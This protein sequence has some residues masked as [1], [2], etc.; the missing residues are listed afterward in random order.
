[1]KCY[2]HHDADAVGVCSQCGQGVCDACA[3][4]I[5]GKLYCKEDADRV[6]SPQRE[7]EAA[8]IE[9]PMR[10]QVASIFFILYGV[11]G[12]GVG[13][14][15]V[16]AGFA[17]GLISSV[18][19]Y[20]SLAI[21][22]LGLLGFGGLLLAMGI[23]GIICGVWLWRVQV[24]GAAIGMPL[25]FVGMMI[26][27]FIVVSAPALITFELMITIWAINA[28]LLA[29]LTFTWGKLKSFGESVPEF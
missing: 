9:K 23:V 12:V 18:P 26:V 17:S 22:S 11:F 27:L 25:L 4:R 21:T 14:L 29:I 19:F 3:V 28:V 10:A 6:F 20:G 13:I 1:L 5:G 24:W 8:A 15:F 2:V 16:M 7:R